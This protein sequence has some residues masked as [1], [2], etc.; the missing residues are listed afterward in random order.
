MTESP[1]VA[2]AAVELPVVAAAS[3]AAGA[4][5]GESP[6]DEA[7]RLEAEAKARLP[8]PEK[9]AAA[10]AWVEGVVERMGIK[11]AVLADD[12]PEGIFIRITPEL[13]AEALLGS[14]RGEV[15]ESLGYLL[16]KALNR[17]EEGRKWVFLEV[18]AE[19]GPVSTVDERSHA[20]SEQLVAHAR[21]AGGTLWVTALPSATRGPLDAALRAMPGVRFRAEGEGLHRRFVIEVTG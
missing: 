5:G 16:N 10:Q 12:R 7:A 15:I 20:L 8:N 21:K 6:A 11:A 1:A 19:A 18:I 9:T 13:P 17:E 3:L 4:A 2:P 14:R